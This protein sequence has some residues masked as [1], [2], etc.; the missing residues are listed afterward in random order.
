MRFVDWWGQEKQ[1][2]EDWVAW[3]IAYTKEKRITEL[4]VEKE[5][6]VL[7][8]FVWKE[9]RADWE[10]CRGNCLATKPLEGS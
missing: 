6:K 2:K 5:L 1:R 8:V 4:I 9:R 7:C 3:I 10:E